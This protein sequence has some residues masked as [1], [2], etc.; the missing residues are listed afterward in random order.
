[1]TIACLE[2]VA[3]DVYDLFRLFQDKLVNVTETPS[4]LEGLD[5]AETSSVLSSLQASYKSFY[6]RIQD[7]LEQAADLLAMYGFKIK[8]KLEPLHDFD[9]PRKEKVTFTLDDEDP[10][11]VVPSSSSRSAA[12]EEGASSS[13]PS[14][15]STAT[16][17]TSGVGG[18]KRRRTS[19][20]RKSAGGVSGGLKGES[21]LEEGMVDDHLTPYDDATPWDQTLEGRKRPQAAAAQAAARRQAAAAARAVEE[22]EDD[23]EEGNEGEEED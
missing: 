5:E 14:P 1:M 3:R 13:S 4:L 17:A 18:I 2:L 22:E 21:G 10:I 11:T 15:P 16:G 6:P 9:A 8:T 12:G 23:D 20:L 19:P 7:F